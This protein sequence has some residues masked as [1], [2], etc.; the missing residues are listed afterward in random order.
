MRLSTEPD[1]DDTKSI[2]VL[3]AALEAGITLLDTAD[4]YCWDDGDRGH[5]ER[6]IARALAT[7]SGDRSRVTVATKGG[8][9][10]PGGRWEPDG[11]AK[12]LTAACEASRRAL[13]VERIDLYQLH[14]PDPRV[15][16]ATS[17]RALAALKRDGLISAIGLANVTVGQIE[18]AR[19]IVE[20]DSIQVELSLWHDAHFLS[21]VAEYCVAHGLQLLAYRPLGGRR[22]LSRNA[23]DPTLRDIAEQH[24]ATPFEIALAWLY[25]LSDVIVPLPGAT[26]V[27]TA[28]SAARARLVQ[29]TERDRERLDALCSAARGLRHEKPRTTAPRRNDAEIVLVMGLPGAG[30][31]TLAQELA[32]NGSMRINRDEEGGTL[33][34]LLPALDSALVA[35]ATQIVLDNTYVS[36]KS[37]AAVTNAAAERGVAVRCI[38]LTTSVEHAQVNAVT[39]LLNRYGKLLDEDELAAARK[40]DV[41][42]FPP[43]VQFRYQRELE[44]PNVAEGFSRV[45]VVPFERRLDPT[46]V[47]RALIVWCDGI[48]LRSRAQ[49]RV[50]ISP[51]DVV[52]DVERA[53]V[54]HRYRERG[55]R[56]LGMSWQPEIAAGTRSTAAADA[57]FARMNELMG[58]DLD[59]AYCPHAAGP[60]RCWCRKPLPGLGV[61]FIERYQLN[62]AACIYVG[63][64][65]QDPGFAR[66]LGFQY[67]D[68]VE[69]FTA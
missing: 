36:R 48:L 2:G 68:A 51:D 21:G 10:R 47:N 41:A 61:L 27:E 69:L 25:D 53:A 29:L 28:Q 30:K 63:E 46:Y 37:R 6:L 49:H 11:R 31:T 56:L 55:Y 54:L 38:W 32:A 58:I 35:G 67:R 24:G 14:A 23:K 3:H 44:P 33:R 43:T 20:I 39:R 7:W 42:A 50:P 62:P 52:V 9:I 64:G 4:A 26:R 57:V 34:E 8:I 18:E 45:D 15:P 59:V 13:A 40:Q 60:P 65:P 16:L 19:R 17:V 12:H 66:R 5:N 1:R 22:A